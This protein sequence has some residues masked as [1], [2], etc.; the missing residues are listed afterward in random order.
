MDLS[1][2]I[3]V[4]RLAVQTR[5]F[6]LYEI[7]DGVMKFSQKITDAKPVKEYLQLQGRFKH[8]NDD[9]IQRIQDFVNA[10]YDFLMGIEGVR[11]F[12]VLY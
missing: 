6:P 1:Q 11:T 10:R 3:K 5:A 9:E 7:E 8:L 4:A 12:D 2:T